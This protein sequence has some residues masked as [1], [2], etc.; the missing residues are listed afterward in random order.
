MPFEVRVSDAV[1]E[2]SV[3]VEDAS[4]DT[5]LIE[6]PIVTR[7]NDVVELAISVTEI[8]A[9]SE[10]PLFFPPLPLMGSEVESED[11]TEVEVVAL[12]SVT[13]ALAVAS[14]PVIVTVDCTSHVRPGAPR[15]EGPA[16]AN[17]LIAAKSVLENILGVVTRKFDFFLKNL[18]KS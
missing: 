16:T 18:H 9:L 12:T 4:T 1:A 2:E 3:T 8:E 14:P 6:V 11:A 15:T 13:V 17:K 5:S 7:P 10:P